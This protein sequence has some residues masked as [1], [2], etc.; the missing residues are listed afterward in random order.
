[1]SRRISRRATLTG[2]AAMIA[3]AGVRDTAGA[4]AP[5]TLGS[6]P[7]LFLDDHLIQRSAG[8]TRR[9]RS[10]ERQLSRPVVTGPED[11]NF[12]PYVTVVRDPQSRRFRMW[13]NVPVSTSQSHLAYLE[14][15]DGVRWIRPHRVLKDPDTI[16]FGAAV[17]D[18]GPDGPEPARRFKFGWWHG[19]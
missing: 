10:P 13:Y 14:S 11:K 1:M 4:E 17:I 8:V 5:L 9:I 18:D 19:G 12:Q 16:Q 7:H 15:E 2:A 3:A 6:G